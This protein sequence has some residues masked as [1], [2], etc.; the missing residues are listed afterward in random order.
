MTP[1]NEKVVAS[2]TEKYFLL[3]V[4]HFIFYEFAC[5]EGKTEVLIQGKELFS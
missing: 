1:S 2:D 4:Q 3:L 5:A